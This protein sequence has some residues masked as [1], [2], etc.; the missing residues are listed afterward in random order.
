M[1]ALARWLAFLVMCMAT[2]AQDTPQPASEP[3]R[4]GLLAQGVYWKGLFRDVEIVSWGEARNPPQPL[5]PV[6]L[7]LRWN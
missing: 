5:V 2:G 7:P 4:V 3:L 6:G 1:A